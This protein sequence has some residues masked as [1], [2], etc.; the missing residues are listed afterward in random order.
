MSQAA[1]RPFP[2]WLRRRIPSGDEVEKVRS[3]LSDLRL[4]T[5]CQSARC[6]NIYDCF[7][8]RTATFMILGN[9]C[10]RDCAFC[11]VSHGLPQPP[12]PDEPERVAEAARALGLRYVVVTSVTRDDLPDGGAEHFRRTVLA[13]KDKAGTLVEVLT[14]DFGGVRKHVETVLSAG[15]AVFNHNLETVR[16]LYPVV[17]PQAGYRRSLDLLRWARETSSD[18]QTKSGLMVG[19]GETGAELSEALGDLRGVGC[20]VVTIGQYLQP[21]KTRLPVAR[22]VPPAEFEAYKREALAL[23]FRAVASGP[24]VRSSY[25][26]ESLAKSRSG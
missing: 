8:R 7:S 20:D 13:L 9:L 12:D 18:L 1:A 14:P 6:P 15:P 5:V 26:A 25:H 11:A 3:L 24:F 19:L 17:R 16:R 21:G 10:T 2:P 22:F 4:H 23:G